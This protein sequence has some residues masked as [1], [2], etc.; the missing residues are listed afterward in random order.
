M[1]SRNTKIYREKLSSIEVSQKRKEEPY[2]IRF[3]VNEESFTTI[4]IYESERDFLEDFLD[5]KK[6][7]CK[8]VFKGDCIDPEKMNVFNVFIDGDFVMMVNIKEWSV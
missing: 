7:L 1:L 3:A 4:N 2:F 5:G 8:H 6:V